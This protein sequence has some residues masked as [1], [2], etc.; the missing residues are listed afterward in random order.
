MTKDDKV[1][2]NCPIIAS[3]FAA[4]LARVLAAQLATKVTSAPDIAWW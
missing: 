3:P 2:P 1:S 4:Q